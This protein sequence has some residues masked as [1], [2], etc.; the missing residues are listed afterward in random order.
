MWTWHQSSGDLSHD[1]SHVA[2]GYSGAG[3]GKNN[4]AFQRVH[5]VGPIPQGNVEDQWTAC[6][7]TNA[8]PVCSAPV[9]L[10]WY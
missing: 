7:Y 9:S 3:D 6:R 2:H 1:G 8:W 10:S 5:N 4:P